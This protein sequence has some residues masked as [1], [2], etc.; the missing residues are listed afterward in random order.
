M[1]RIHAGALLTRPPGGKYAAALDFAELTLP[2]PLPGARTLRRW[3]Q[4]IP[5][6]MVLSLV[7]TRESTRSE[8]GPLRFDDAMETEFERMREAATILDV[9]FVVLTTAGDITTGRRDRDLLRAWVER[10]KGQ[11]TIVWQPT[12]LWDPELAAPFAE[13]L[14]AIYGFDP[15]ETEAPPGALIYARLRALGA[16]KRFDE[17]Q[18]LEV[19]DTLETSDADEAFV[20]LNSPASFREASRLVQ[21][22]S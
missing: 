4:E 19:V 20:A 10:W 1:T 7:V 13:K 15:L 16:R 5:S 6:N 2:K 9:R 22:G 14:G 12:G 21:L 11:R 17:T 8:K 18:L 3:R